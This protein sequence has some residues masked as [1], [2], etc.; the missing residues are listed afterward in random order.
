MTRREFLKL[1]A[2]AGGTFALGPIGRAR[3]GVAAAQAGA[4]PTV[5]RL[6]M[7]N[8]VD[9]VYDVFAKDGRFGVITVARTRLTPQRTPLLAEHGL[10]FHLESLRGSERREILLDFSLT[11]KGLFNN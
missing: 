8:V 3:R 5:D 9:N 1:G 11:D 2:I 7:T 10:A 4:I 6:V